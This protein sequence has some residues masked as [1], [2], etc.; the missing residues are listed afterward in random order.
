MSIQYEQQSNQPVNITNWRKDEEYTQYPEG[1]R[2]KTR[3]YSPDSPESPPYLF[4]KS[5]HPY[6][7]KLSAA[8][9]TEQFWVEIFAYRLGLK[10]DIPVPPAFVAYDTNTK[11]I[12][13]LIEWFFSSPSEDYTSGGDYCQEQIP[14]FDRKKGKQ[15]NFE[16]ISEIFTNLSCSDDWLS[17]WAKALLF[18][19]L[20]GNNDRHQDNW[21]TV[22]TI[23]SI[24]GKRAV[25]SRR[26]APVFDNG[27]SMGYE[28]LSS[29]FKTTNVAKY[30]AHGHHHMKWKL[31]DLKPMGHS[32]MIRKMAETYPETRSIMIN[33]LKSVNPE[34]FKQILDELVN[35]DLS[36]K[37]TEER[38]SFM[39]NLLQFRYQELLNVL[40]N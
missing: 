16:L 13:V 12:G 40:E 7:F 24:E 23:A 2:D 25:I 39:L 35:F 19:A 34:I 38:S 37:L 29:R 3:L 33:C 26:I 6:L 15:H 11:Q 30:V 17:Y 9:G 8:R 28:I 27:S 18:D 36:I 14:T 21:G 4:L 32:A 22:E 10:M 5:E 20:I 31:E 1:A